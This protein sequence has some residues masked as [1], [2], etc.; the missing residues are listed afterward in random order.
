[1]SPQSCQ[2]GKNGETD[3]WII[4]VES[5]SK[6]SMVKIFSICESFPLHSVLIDMYGISEAAVCPD[7]NY[8]KDGSPASQKEEIE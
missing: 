1:M 6:N 7:D 4:N 5:I 3:Q 8:E 2:C